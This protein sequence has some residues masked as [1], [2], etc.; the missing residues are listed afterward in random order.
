[1]GFFDSVA[2]AVLG[3]LGGQEGNMAQ[4]AIDLFN[5][6]GG[7]EGILE[8][9]RENGLAQQAASWV[10]SGENLSVTPEQVARVL[11]EGEIAQMAAKFGLTPE[12]ISNKIA[13]HLPAI[14]DKLTPNG[15]VGGGSGN[16]LNTVL[17]M[18]KA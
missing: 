17:S 12:F 7:V 13:E 6:N 18:L 9:F 10:G 1:M 14:V 11:G 15:E 8:K 2:G 16:L 4:V 5:Q 3:K